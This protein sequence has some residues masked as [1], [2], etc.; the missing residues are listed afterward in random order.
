MVHKVRS[1]PHNGQRDWD[2]MRKGKQ[3]VERLD[4]ADKFPSLFFSSGLEDAFQVRYIP[5]AKYYLSL[6][7]APCFSIQSYLVAV[8]HLYILFIRCC[9][10]T[11][12]VWGISKKIEEVRIQKKSHLKNIS[13]THRR[14]TCPKSVALLGAMRSDG[15]T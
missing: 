13:R 5:S 12:R 9:N 11:A 1:P 2:D 3:D 14:T 15:A 8:Y 4:D 6:R 10:N 7:E